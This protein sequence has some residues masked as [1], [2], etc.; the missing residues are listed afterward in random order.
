MT[1]IYMHV[2]I[3]LLGLWE[4]QNLAGRGE[5]AN[6]GERMGL[7]GRAGLRHQQMAGE[8]TF[9]ACELGERGTAIQ[10]SRSAELAGSRSSCPETAGPRFQ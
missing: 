4:W 10:S 8:S 3:W 1:G 2:I 7:A 6:V 5:L 9:G